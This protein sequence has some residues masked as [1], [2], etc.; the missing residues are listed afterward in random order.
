M[1]FWYNLV[2][3]WRV[4][5]VMDQMLFKKWIYQHIPMHPLLPEIWYAHSFPHYD[6]NEY[7]EDLDVFITNKWGGIIFILRL[8]KDDSVKIL[9]MNLEHLGFVRK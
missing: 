2:E 5:S 4:V 6:G 7:T 1:G 3:D 8:E 9:Q